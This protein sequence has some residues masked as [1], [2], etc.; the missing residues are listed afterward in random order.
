MLFSFLENTQEITI[1]AHKTPDLDTLCAA[2]SLYNILKKSIKINLICF[3]SIPKK[4]KQ[5]IK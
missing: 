5:I 4:Y 3:D 1:I 2:Q